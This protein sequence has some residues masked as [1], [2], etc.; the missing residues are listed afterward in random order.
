MRPYSS[1]KQI[2]SW[3]GVIKILVAQFWLEFV[4]AYSIME[5]VPSSSGL[6]DRSTIIQY[7]FI[8]CRN[9][10]ISFTFI[11]VQA[12]VGENLKIVSFWRV[13][14]MQNQLY[15][16]RLKWEIDSKHVD[17]FIRTRQWSLI[18]FIGANKWTDSVYQSQTL[19][20]ELTSALYRESNWSAL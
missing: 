9:P 16:K 1:I 8:Y 6:F 19:L 10:S 18:R 2:A 7:S 12:I 14:T 5:G 20:Y 13:S 15:L 11:L 3:F 17:T 4:K